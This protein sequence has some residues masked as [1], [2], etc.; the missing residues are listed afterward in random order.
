MHFVRNQL[1]KESYCVLPV[2]VSPK[3]RTSPEFRS[4]GGGVVWMSRLLGIV[5]DR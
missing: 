1:E 3:P 5:T 2:F 4:I